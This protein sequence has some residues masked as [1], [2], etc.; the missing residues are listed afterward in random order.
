MKLFGRIL[1]LFEG[2]ERARAWA[3][4]GALVL[5]AGLETVGVGLVMPFIA[6]VTDPGLVDEAP[7]LGRLR[8]VLGATDA[9]QLLIRSGLLLLGFYVAKNAFV[10]ALTS[11]QNRF[12]YG[13][14]QRLATRLLRAYLTAPYAFHLERNSAELQR[15]VNHNVPTMFTWVVAQSFI[16]VSDVLVVAILGALLVVVNPVATIAAGGAFGV[17]GFAYLGVMRRRTQALG[18]R[19]QASLAEMLKWVNQGL[20]AL[21]ETRVRGAEGFFVGRYREHCAEYS[22]ARRVLQTVNEY[23]RLVLETA[24]VA[25]VVLVIVAALLRGGDAQA[26]IPLVAL[27][28]A[29]SFRLLP[30]MTRIIRSVHLIKH[31]R[32]SFDAVCGDLELLRRVP[33]TVLEPGS[34]AR[35]PMR[36]RIELRDVVFGYA[37]SAE[38]VLDGVSLVIERG[39]CVAIVGSSG[40]GK[41][42]LVDL[43]LGLFSPTS[44]AIL[45][46]GRDVREDPD[47]WRRNFGYIPQDIYL[48]DDTI[49]RNVAF[50]VPDTAIDDAAV[51]RALT[52]AQLDEF[53]AGL[54]GGLDHVVGEGG[55]RLSGGQRQ[56]IGIAR[57]LYH[58]PP[59]L[60]MDEATSAL[61]AHTEREINETILRLAGKRTVI[62]I[63]HRLATVERCDRLFFLKDGRLLAEG[64]YEDLAHPLRGRR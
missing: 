21:K 1:D 26:L 7:L 2:R 16:V 6:L 33:D 8:D 45:A 47:G 28:A 62:V 51:R 19:E 37:G 39:R 20:G 63:A 43:V 3:L 52:A 53:V 15:N 56:R 17:L 41:T 60:V 23:P 42:T 4:L 10:A 30:S 9:N 44:G 22:G 55:V 61:D 24:A 11:A 38:P 31:F 5:A 36:E 49:R 14:M 54:P 64:T 12:V 13:K 40:A 32:P 46:D 27:F 59:V 50:G 58:D 34:G 18:E 48:T 35:M 29:A 25:G 57:A